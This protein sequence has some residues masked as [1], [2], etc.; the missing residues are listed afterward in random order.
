MRITRIIV[1]FC[2]EECTHELAVDDDV[3]GFGYRCSGYRN[4]A[5]DG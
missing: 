4:G 1:G 3:D 5:G 2:Y